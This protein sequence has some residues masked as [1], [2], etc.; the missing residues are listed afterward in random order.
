MGKRS[1]SSAMCGFSHG[2]EVRSRGCRRSFLKWNGIGQTLCPSRPFPGRFSSLTTSERTSQRCASGRKPIDR[3][4][5]SESLRSTSPPGRRCRRPRSSPD[6]GRRE[7]APGHLDGF[8]GAV[9][10]LQVSSCFAD[11]VNQRCSPQ[12]ETRRLG[13][14]R[15]E[16]HADL[17]Q[18]A[19]Q[20]AERVV[21]GCQ[22][23]VGPFVF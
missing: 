2:R 16:I 15:A 22:L 4:S 23:E 13:V 1:T 18:I 7:A 11:V 8:R 17:E 6:R 3:F 20:V 9:T 10:P 12:V 19:L 21:A 5:W 14:R